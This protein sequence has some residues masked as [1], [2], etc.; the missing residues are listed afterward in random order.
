MMKNYS[1]AAPCLCCLRARRAVAAVRPPGR[2]PLPVPLG[3]LRREKSDGRRAGG[4]GSL[5]ST[6]QSVSRI[7]RA[8]V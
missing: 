3:R 6:R 4:Q 7:C 8:S 1:P 5:E 2:V